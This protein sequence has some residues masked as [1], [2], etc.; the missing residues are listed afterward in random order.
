M[1][2]IRIRKHEVG[3][4]FRHGD[5]E[6]L[7][8]PGA[9]WIP[10]RLI[11]IDRVTVIDTLRTRFEHPLLDVLVAEPTLRERLE[12]VDLSATQRALV[13]KDGR[14]ESILGPGR[15]AFWKEPYTLDIEV[16]DAMQARLS[17]PRI[18]AVLSHADAA[19]HLKSVT[20]PQTHRL[21]VLEDGRLVDTLGPGKYAFW[22]LNGKVTWFSIDL[23]EKVLD[24]AG[25]E[26]MTADK[27]TLRINLIVTYRVSDPVAAVTVVADAD[28]ALYREAQLALRAAV[29]ARVLEKLL[30]AKEVVTDE[31]RAAVARRAAGFGVVVVA[32]GMRDVILPG[33]MKTILNQV[34][35]AQKK[36]EANLIRRREETAAARSQANTAKLLGDNPMLARMKELEA[37]QEILAGARTTFVFGQGPLTEQIRSLVAESPEEG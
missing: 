33:D 3:L 15:H 25:Q 17:H 12:V 9:Y 30:T 29:G 21:V 4:W 16:H 36:A 8:G 27:V 35:E 19:T 28:Q 31:V 5:L 11:G 26:I 37:L 6:Q 32:V 18:D 20:V 23:R 24:V 13:W 10:G 14:L 2:R 34:I 7:L 1:K 22:T